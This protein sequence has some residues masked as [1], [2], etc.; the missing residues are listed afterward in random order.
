MTKYHLK[1]VITLN[2]NNYKILLFVF[3]IFQIFRK[4]LHSNIF[5]L[6]YNII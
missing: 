4:T 2:T 6:S 5:T 3:F 1:L